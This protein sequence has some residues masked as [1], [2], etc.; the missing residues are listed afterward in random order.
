MQSKITFF[1]LALVI[2]I[3]V[4]KTNIDILSSL[5]LAKNTLRYNSFSN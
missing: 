5:F 4:V 2:N 1:E 3:R